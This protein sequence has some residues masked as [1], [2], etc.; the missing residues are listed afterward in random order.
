MAGS[1][2]S[3]P[4]SWYLESWDWLRITSRT[5]LICCNVGLDGG[6]VSHTASGYLLGWVNAELPALLVPGKLGLAE[7]HFMDSAYLL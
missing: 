4:P 1:T 5:Q 7:D 2:L 6:G 3:C